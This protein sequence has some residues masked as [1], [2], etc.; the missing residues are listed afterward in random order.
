[1]SQKFLAVFFSLFLASVA[2]AA[3]HPVVDSSSEYPDPRPLEVDSLCISEK[4]V[5]VFY[6]KTKPVYQ[7]QSVLEVR[8]QG[9]RCSHTGRAESSR[10][11]YSEGDLYLT[12]QD[13]QVDFEANVHHQDINSGAQFLEFNGRRYKFWVRGR[14]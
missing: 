3:C 2:Q 6:K 1:M 14:R 4:D 10:C 7:F 13:Q 9:Y 8:N 5:V 11:G 12:Y